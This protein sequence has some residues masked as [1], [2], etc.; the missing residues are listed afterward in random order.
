MQAWA[1]F[2][3]AAV[4]L[5]V[6]IKGATAFDVWRRQKIEERRMDAAERILTLAYRVRRALS[7]IRHPMMWAAALEAAKKTR[8]EKG[9]APG[10]LD[11]GEGKNRVYAQATLDRINAFSAEWDEMA[12]I[13]PIAAA[14]FGPKLETDLER[15]WRQRNIVAGAAEDY[16]EDD[17]SDRDHT[18][19][20]RADL[21][22]N[23]GTRNK[24]EDKV[25]I[26]VAAAISDIEG[27]LLPV[28]RAEGV[29]KRRAPERGAEASAP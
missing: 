12:A 10:T 17:G 14:L 6:G 21:W 1:G 22:E 25:S 13:T 4:I 8:I 19:R 2:A 24:D 9:D 28:I 11:Q 23:L 3:Q 26:E 27:T 29:A 7:S 20:I 5:F 18:R 16:A 15:L